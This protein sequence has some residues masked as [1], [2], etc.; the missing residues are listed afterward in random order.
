[1]YWI[2]PFTLGMLKSLQLEPE[3]FEDEAGQ[4]D[5]TMAHAVERVIGELALAAGQKVIETTALK[6]RQTP[7]AIKKPTVVS[8]F[9]LPQFHQTDENDDWWGHGY[10][11][12]T[13]V[14][15][16]KRQYENHLLHNPSNAL[17]VYDLQ[18]VEVLER[19]ATM[20]RSAGVDAFC[21]YHYW[22]G[23][24]RML[25]KPIDQLL[26]SKSTEFPFYLCWANESWRRNW[27]GLSG[28][29]LIEQTYP[30]GFEQE[31][32]KQT[33]AYMMDPRY[34]K[35]DG[36]RPRFII[37]RPNCLPDPRLN[38]SRLREEWRR[39]GIGDVEVGG[40][41]FHTEI[42]NTEHDLVDFWIEMP[43]HGLFDAGDMLTGDAAPDG[44]NPKF[45]GVIY[46]YGKLSNRAN[47]PSYVCRLPENCIRGVMPSWDNTARR[48]NS[49]HIA[50]GA[51]PA[52]FRKWL[53][54]L[55]NRGPEGGYQ[56]ELMINAWNEWGE[57]AML[58]PSERFG[59][60]N[61]DALSEYTC[62]K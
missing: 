8:A 41:L 22:F 45:K 35:P 62:A 14:Q 50:Y 25:E 60:L 23:K 4:L 51:T 37:Y 33:A 59:T 20:A 2:K 46:D 44:L 27:D 48:G 21:V 40:V 30:A 31:L 6:A 12:W 39:I 38:I 43:P 32:A 36:M 11:E 42:N 5:G 56:N 28:E 1:M 58:E 61:L 54:G 3:D 24:K 26:R 53:Q 47:T 49:A 15:S 52:G 34:Q 18:D 17:G 57:K 10:T 9:Y 55:S 29:I 19:Q 13:A 7:P 16:S